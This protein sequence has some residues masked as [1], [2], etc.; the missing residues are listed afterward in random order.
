MTWSGSVGCGSNLINCPASST[1]MGTPSR[2]RMR[3]GAMAETRGPGV[4]MPARFKDQQALLRA[5]H[6]G[7]DA[8]VA[9]SEELPDRVGPRVPDRQPDD[10]RR[11]TFQEAPLPE[12]IVLRD[13]GKSLKSSVLPDGFVRM[14]MEA[15]VIDV[16][17]ARKQGLQIL[18][19]M[20]TE[21]LVKQQLHAARE[22]ARRRSLAAAN[23]RQAR[24]SSRLR[25]GKSVRI[26]SSVMP[27]AK[28]SRMSYTVIRVPLMHGLPL[29]IPGSMMM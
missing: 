7:R 28:Y 1:A 12:I 29:R 25:L 8:S 21:V 2:S 22:L 23:A 20:R 3:L 24:M 18:G 27:P 26:W 9:V 5:R 4:R 10:F 19:K 13:D 17:A 14:T 6:K 16:L 15:G 11:R